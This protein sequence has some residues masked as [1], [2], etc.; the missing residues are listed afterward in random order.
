MWFKRNIILT[1]FFS[2]ACVILFAQTA[3]ITKIKVKWDEK[4]DEKVLPVSKSL[5]L[6]NGN[7]LVFSDQLV[8]AL[9]PVIS[10]GGG[11][12]FQLSIVDQERNIIKTKSYKAGNLCSI[13]EVGWLIKLK[14]RYYITII[15]VAEG[16][17]V[18]VFE[19][20]TETLE[21]TDTNK[22]LKNYE[23][24]K[25]EHIFSS[26]KSGFYLRGSLVKEKKKSYD[27]SLR[28]YD[29]DLNAILDQSIKLPYKEAD[30]RGYDVDSEG[31][32]YAVVFFEE[33]K[34][35]EEGKKV[36]ETI[37]KI[38]VTSVKDSEIETVEIEEN[39]ERW[40]ADFGIKTRKDGEGIILC[41]QYFDKEIT[42]NP[43]P[44][45]GIY[46]AK[47]AVE[48]F[49]IPTA[50]K[51][52]LYYDRSNGF[53]EPV[54]TPY[55][56]KVLK[57]YLSEKDKKALQKKKNKKKKK[58]DKGKYPKFLNGITNLLVS[59]IH[60]LENGNI[61]EFSEV[62]HVEI[63]ETEKRSEVYRFLGK[64]ILTVFTPKGEV[65][66]M[67][68]IDKIHTAKKYWTPFSDSFFQQNCIGVVFL[69]GKS[70]SVYMY[71]MDTG[72]RMKKTLTSKE[73]KTKLRVDPDMTKR[74]N[75]QTFLIHRSKG[76]KSQFGRII[77]E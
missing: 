52:M 65:V 1:I 13:C 19:V 64:V 32:V 55:D 74:I 26:T 57:P 27:L 58:K 68:S 33:K 10:A 62:Y 4:G 76:K 11:K 49:G 7:M 42:E 39:G 37:K 70:S 40:L 20:N 75:D 51:A 61:F 5:K 8:R 56:R 36:K 16:K 53:S 22:R 43:S 31:N 21:L 3:P 15:P 63:I 48:R 60:Y 9:A 71:D 14:D 18:M 46:T 2:L 35:N 50:G 41:G 47:I 34:K 17:D 59:E 45:R 28:L 77:F 72:K 44:D 38:F 54:Y 67:N 30:L 25:K 66:W 69:D 12:K 23:K 6:E 29:T 73:E 24:G